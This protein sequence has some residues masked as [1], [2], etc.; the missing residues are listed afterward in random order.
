MRIVF[1]SRVIAASI[2]R[3]WHRL[4]DTP[5]RP[6]RC[7]DCGKPLNADEREHY[8]IECEQCVGINMERLDR[9]LKEDTHEAA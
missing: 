5:H 7:Y 8:E 4:R 9:A 2:R 3:A 6:G 1:D